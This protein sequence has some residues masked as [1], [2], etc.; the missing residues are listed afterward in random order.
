L[1]VEESKERT[2]TGQF[3]VAYDHT[4][5]EKH[6]VTALALYEAIDYKTNWIQAQRVNYLT[7]NIQQLYA[8]SS[9]GMSNDGNAAEMGRTSYVGRLNY[10]YMGKYLLETILRADASAKFP[11]EKRWGYFPSVSA[12]WRISEETFMH[13]VQF[14]DNLKIRAGY[15][16]SGND[17]VGNFQYL[18]G[19]HFDPTYYFGSG[20]EQSLT[21]T[22]LAN[23]NLTWEKIKIYNAGF[24]FSVLKRQL[25]GEAD[26]FYRTRNGIPETRLASLPSTFGSNLPPEN[27]NSLNDRGFELVLGTTNRISD[28]SY[29]ISGNISWSRA[30][31]DHFEEPE[32]EDPDQERLNKRSGK[33]TD[34][35][36]GYIANKLFSSQEE[37]DALFFDQDQQGN[38]TLR[39]GDVRFTDLNGDGLLDWKDQTEIG[40][41]TIPHWM[42]GLNV[43][44]AYKN[45]DFSALFQGAFGYYK[46]LVFSNSMTTTYF[47]ER[48]TEENNNIHAL[49]PRLGGS[50]LNWFDSDYFYKSAGYFRLKTAALGYSLPKQW[51]QTFK[52]QQFRI[53]LAGTN[54][55]TFD[56]LKK[57]KLDPEAPSGVGSN[58]YPQQRTLTL[59]VTLSF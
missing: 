21:A 42:A 34:W 47:E 18:S 29:D 46:Q 13:S 11:P 48:W 49:V 8:G 59:G 10:A 4:F 40:A 53:Y 12:G 3:S 22:G 19:Y 1:T 23:P 55:L 20:P 57:Y 30:K 36:V 17:G 58:F 9:S 44:L 32:Y 50:S 15:G 52:I 14:I 31:W 7:P 28:F 54:L 38:K 51:L 16:E 6:H 56:K 25:Y 43:N 39:P 35:H 26:V 27:I 37:I 5:A 45:F 24:E 2:L 33:W 41:G